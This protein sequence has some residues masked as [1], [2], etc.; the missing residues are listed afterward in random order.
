MIL[1]TERSTDN[2]NQGVNRP[3]K[4]TAKTDLMQNYTIPVDMADGYEGLA[5]GFDQMDRLADP[6]NHVFVVDEDDA[7]QV[8]HYFP[9]LTD[10]TM[11]QKETYDLPNGDEV[12]MMV[13]G[14][15]GN[16][17]LVVFALTDDNYR[18]YYRR[19]TDVAWSDTG[20][21]VDNDCHNVTISAA[22][23]AGQLR[24]ALGYTQASG[25]K[26]QAFWID[27]SRGSGRYTSATPQYDQVYTVAAGS[28][29]LPGRNGLV[30]GMLIAW[31]EHHDSHRHVSFFEFG[32][33]NSAAYDFVNA[34]T[35]DHHY[36]DLVI[37]PYGNDEFLGRRSDGHIHYY[38]GDTAHQ[39]L[40]DGY[41]IKRFCVTQPAA[42]EESE[43]SLQVFAISDDNNNKEEDLV[44]YSSKSKRTQTW[45]DSLAIKSNTHIV[46]A[47][48]RDQ[49]VNLFTVSNEDTGGM[50]MMLQR[51]PG[52]SDWRTLPISTPLP[53]ATEDVKNGEQIAVGLHQ[54][55]PSAA[56]VFNLFKIRSGSQGK[57]SRYIQTDPV[58]DLW[59]KESYDLPNGRLATQ[60][61]CTQNEL[62]ELT[63]AALDTHLNVYYRV[64]GQSQWDNFG[65]LEG[66]NDITDMFIAAGRQEGGIGIFVGVNR[67]N[68]HS[69][70]FELSYRSSTGEKMW[71]WQSTEYKKVYAIASGYYTYNGTRLNGAFVSAKTDDNQY[72]IQWYPYQ[73]SIYQ[74]WPVYGRN[75]SGHYSQIQ[76]QV[77]GEDGVFALKSS[78]KRL[79]LYR[80]NGSYDQLF[81]S[82]QIAEFVVALPN[83]PTSGDKQQVFGLTTGGKIKVTVQNSNGS[84]SSPTQIASDGQALSGMSTRVGD[85]YYSGLADMRDTYV[86]D[87]VYAAG[88]QSGRIS[89][90]TGEATG[91]PTE[92]ASYMT[93]VTIGDMNEQGVASAPVSFLPNDSEIDVSLN[94]VTYRLNP[95]DEPLTLVT[96]SRGKATFTVTAT[97]LATPQLLIWSDSFMSADDALL[98]Q[99]NGE[100]QSVLANVNKNQLQNAQ[101]KDGSGGTTDLF[102]D[103]GVVDDHFVNSVNDAMGLADG[104]PDMQLQVSAKSRWLGSRSTPGTTQAVRRS[105][106]HKHRHLQNGP[107]VDK[108][109]MITFGHGRRGRHRHVRLNRQ[110]AATQ[111]SRV[112]KSGRSSEGTPFNGS[113][114]DI[115]RSAIDGDITLHELVIT[116]QGTSAID[117]MDG[118]TNFFKAAVSFV[119]DG[120]TYVWDKT[121]SLI[122]E[123]FDLAEAIFADVKVMF[124]DIFAWLGNFFLWGDV[125]NTQTFLKE[126]ALEMLNSLPAIVRSSETYISDAVQQFLDVDVSGLISN[127]NLDGN[128]T[129]NQTV[130]QT[131]DPDADA[132]TDSP[133]ANWL[134]DQFTQMIDSI[135]FLLEFAESLES[136][137]MDLLSEMLSIL[138]QAVVDDFQIALK[139]LSDLIMEWQGGASLNQLV[140][141]GLEATQEIVAR[142][143]QALAEI[144]IASL[145]TIGNQ[146]IPVMIELLDAPIAIPLLS[147]LYTQVINPGHEL[148][149]LDWVAL[150]GALPATFGY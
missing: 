43:F 148:S 36:K 144:V 35:S 133:Q 141:Q 90:K 52:A 60:I 140:D 17:R 125:L 34:K 25:N 58:N 16:G 85:H 75:T 3:D 19:V 119:W 112:S 139:S 117:C 28:M 127:P 57:I 83:S 95:T 113:F 30:N 101:K 6:V 134:I 31:R 143:L 68:N 149:I 51:T 82:D 118:V 124:Q 40:F 93:Q 110:T 27:W 86:H 26:S 71:G 11:W 24:L 88:W 49:F 76:A 10:G 74:P 80:G 89:L 150:L 147:D 15:E 135:E 33:P 22:Y 132:H 121:V 38:D 115:M 137:V 123:A 77:N 5:V 130:A 72:Q 111:F 100:Q 37:S 55:S 103:K 87:Y 45:S 136:A 70:A 46:Q 50:L 32:K 146:I 65:P 126:F 105:Q 69:R 14:Q 81:P 7:N 47:A 63:I 91:Q 41:E 104:T 128:T 102:S 53:D 109:F 99:P 97:T 94:G 98:V 131:T 42:E 23:F 1:Q 13:T 54:M 56:P 84:W 108:H 4:L 62:G 145:D 79:Y 48:S 29:V 12:K 78:D 92:F 21:N 44:L 66:V 107:N 106:A 96:D 120:I 73:N 122:Q 20:I 61:A 116:R 2:Y 114:G 59:D 142:I 129:V 9:S 8:A 64:V 39:R 18:I 138:E 67:P